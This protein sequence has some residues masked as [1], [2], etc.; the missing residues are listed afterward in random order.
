MCLLCNNFGNK[1]TKEEKQNVFQFGRI[2]LNLPNNNIIELKEGQKEEI[3]ENAIAWVIT[4]FDSIIN[5]WAIQW[6]NDYQVKTIQ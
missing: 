3:I 2:Y 1:L 6:E 5:I 4:G